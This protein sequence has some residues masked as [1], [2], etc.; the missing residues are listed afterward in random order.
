MSKNSQSAKMCVLG[1]GNLLMRDEGFGVRAM[2]YL[3]DH[4]V[5]PDNVD[6]VDGGTLGHGLMPLLQDYDRVVVL[7]IVTAQGEPGTVYLLENEDMRK[8]L[9]F[10]DST[11]DTDFVDL[12]QTCD[13]MGC[14]PEC[15][16]IGLE[17]FDFRSMDAEL[18]DE[19]KKVLPAFCR[20]A[21]LEIL[22]RGWANA[23]VRD[24]EAQSPYR[25][26]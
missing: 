7:D 3:R 15:F 23:K 13:L 22:R 2:E 19:A 8:A 17:P 24:N 9:S 16:V 18:T 4:Y 6:F 21:V 1:V 11:H 10:H 25:A 14:R 20:K 12:L 5:W 26:E